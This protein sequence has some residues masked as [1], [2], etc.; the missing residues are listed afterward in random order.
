MA[1]G[2]T[3]STLSSGLFF[4]PLAAADDADVAVREEGSGFRVQGSGE[5]VRFTHPTATVR[6]AFVAGPENGVVR[7]LA[8]AVSGG[9]LRFNPIVLY[10]PA[11]VGKTSVA[12]ALAAARKVHFGRRGLMHPTVIEVTGGEVAQGLAEAIDTASSDE[13]RGRYHGCDL[14]VIDDLHRVANKPAAQ[15]F[16]LAAFDELLQRGAL[17][18]VTLPRAPQAMTSLRAELISRLAGGLV[19]KL[20]PPGTVASRE[21]VRQEAA[22]LS[23]SLNEEQ[24][25][26]VADHAESTFVTAGK[27]RRAVLRMAAGREFQVPSSKFQ[28]GEG[29]LAAKVVCRQVAVAV[30]KHF[31]LTLAEL[32]G[33]SRRQAIVEARSLAMLVARRLCGASYAEIGRQ[34]GNRDHTTVLHACRKVAETIKHDDFTRR[35]AEEITTQVAAEGVVEF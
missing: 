21:L 15:Q 7:V 29:A 30:G 13:F 5:E 32:R 8:A 3:D 12:G 27:L 1:A 17:V 34:F 31:G 33:K 11:G 35:L 24:I 9:E 4:L 14:L 10:G 6:E 18:I 20:A 16:L 19:V 23:V 28:V 22:R 26:R 25:A 2:S